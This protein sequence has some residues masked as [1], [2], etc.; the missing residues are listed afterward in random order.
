MDDVMRHFRVTP[1]SVGVDPNAVF[2][3]NGEILRR[4][5]P[6]GCSV[7]GGRWSRCQEFLESDD[8]D[9]LC[10][11]R[12]VLR[13][14]GYV[15]LGDEIFIRMPKI[16]NWIHPRFWIGVQWRDALLL[17]ARMQKRLI[18]SG[19]EWLATDCHHENVAFIGSNP[20][21]VDLG[22]FSHIHHIHAI[23]RFNRSMVHM[24]LAAVK[25]WD[26]AIKK[27][28]NWKPIER[29]NGWENYGGTSASFPASVSEIKPSTKE[30]NKLK[31][32]IRYLA[33]S[34][35][36][37]VG[38]NCGSIARLASIECPVVCIDSSGQSL[39]GCHE[40]AKALGLPI[41][42]A[43]V[44]VSGPLAV[45]IQFRCEAII[46][47]SVTHHLFRA[48]M[49]FDRQ[50][51]LWKFLGQRNLLVEFVHPEDQHLTN[52]KLPKEYNRDAFVKSLDP[53]WH[54]LDE[55]KPESPT[56]TWFVYERR[57]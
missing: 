2:D 42:V 25:T 21:Y 10:R 45:N 9:L 3:V 28:E 48:G 32:W 7:E 47:S 13:H 33:P 14:K 39:A 56:R 19:S 20:V 26:D 41:T 5:A 49:T 43:L 30:Q 52:W 34:S 15:T 53:Y 11:E 24:G 57:Q 4:V 51:S 35:I 36:L 27:L 6:K 8:Y 54:C 18:E 12:F 40:N 46:V 44:D 38:G 22:S 37:D 1:L 55:A 16:D 31:E 50:A 23:G 29:V 17:I